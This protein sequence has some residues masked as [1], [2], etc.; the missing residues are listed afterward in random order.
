MPHGGPGQRRFAGNEPNDCDQEKRDTSE[1]R[2]RPH[3]D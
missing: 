3:G 2:W 1:E